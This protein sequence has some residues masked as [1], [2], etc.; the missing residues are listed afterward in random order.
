MC[1]Q[2][3]NIKT[4]YFKKQPATMHAGKYDNEAPPLSFSLRVNGNEL[5]T[6]E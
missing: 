1:M 4:K 2:K 3:H 6:F 5:N